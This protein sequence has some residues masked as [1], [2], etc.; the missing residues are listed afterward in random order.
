MFDGQ[1]S[2]LLS[3]FDLVHRVGLDP[4]ADRLLANLVSYMST[5]EGH[6][7]HP[8]IE[9]PIRW[10]NYPTER[11]VVCGSLNGLLVNAEWIPAPRGPKSKRL[12]SN[13]GS[14]NMLPGEQFVPQGRNP[15]GAF[16]YSTASSLKD[17]HSDSETGEGFFWVRVP[18][19]KR[20]LIT[21]VKNPEKRTASLQ[22]SFNEEKTPAS[23]QKIRAGKTIQLRTVLSGQSRNLCIR[24]FGEK[25]LVLLQTAFE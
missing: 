22:V 5:N 10:G 12:P 23:S 18:E 21:T 19:G 13:T 1:G 17:G 14:W 24:Y 7:T 8:L 20:F 3:G 25:T 15:F 9:Q 16:G 2:I 4:A 11:G 6:E